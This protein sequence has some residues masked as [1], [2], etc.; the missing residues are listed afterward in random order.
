MANMESARLTTRCEAM[1][2][3]GL[4]DVK[5]TLG[6]TRGATVEDVC[7]E[8]NSMLDAF[9]AGRFVKLKFDDLRTVRRLG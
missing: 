9:E 5:F 8:V 6:D 2:R 4:V 7:G 3:D 1:R